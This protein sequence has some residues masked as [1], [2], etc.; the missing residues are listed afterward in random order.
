MFGAR[1]I[2]LKTRGDILSLGFK[3]AGTRGSSLAP[4]PE[5]TGRVGCTALLAGGPAG[6]GVVGAHPGVVTKVGG[7]L[8]VTDT[9]R[10][11]AEVTR[12]TL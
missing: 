4:G 7:V 2:T 8:L 6:L 5:L 10:G 11:G 9:V 3:V 1:D 12:G